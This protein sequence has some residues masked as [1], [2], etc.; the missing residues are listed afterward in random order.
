MVADPV[1]VATERRFEPKR[2]LR[3]F[4]RLRGLDGE[5]DGESG[6]VSWSEDERDDAREGES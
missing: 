3:R 2:Q 6:E 4:Q 5:G 1:G